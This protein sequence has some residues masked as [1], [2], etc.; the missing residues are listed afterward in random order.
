MKR[1]RKPP[2]DSLG[3]LLDTICNAFG[4]ILFI[5]LLLAVLVRMTPTTTE[6][7][8]AQGAPS[9]E[10]LRALAEQSADLQSEIKTVTLAVEQLSPLQ[11][12]DPVLQELADSVRDKRSQAEQAREQRSA[13]LQEVA[14]DRAEAAEINERNAAVDAEFEARTDQLAELQGDLETAKAKKTTQTGRSQVEQTNKIPVGI[15][16]RYG[17]M[18]VWHLYS[19]QGVRLGM[20][21]DDMFIV[22]RTP[23]GIVCS[24]IPFKGVP[25]PDDSA[26]G[27]PIVDRLSQFDSDRHFLDIVVWPD[28]FKEF[29]H[30][31]NI[32]VSVGFEYNLLPTDGKDEIRDRGG[33]NHGTQ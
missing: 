7:S 32:L 16:I 15:I 29:G 4:G 3:L 20:N 33:V 8:P 22:E 27:Q 24:P 11:A 17:R 13:T 21:P 12:D 1:R 26:N 31:R 10:E 5:T 19:P 2:L 9:A 28:S 25:I 30:L 6:A 18:Y 14:E 23:R